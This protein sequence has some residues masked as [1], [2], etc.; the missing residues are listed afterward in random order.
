MKKETIIAII[1]GLIFGFVF[2]SFLITRNR[3]INNKNAGKI[4]P[5]LVLNLNDKKDQENL[6]KK[7]IIN[8]PLEIKEPQNY[9]ITEKNT[10]NISG[11][12]DK[13]SLIVVQSQLKEI[14]YINKDSQDFKISDFPLA[15]GENTIK[16]V[17]YSKNKFADPEEKVLR[18]YYLKR[19]I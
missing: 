1:L 18:V 10:I 16:I 5:T 15:L 2:G 17:E 8:I 6:N 7:N 11:K 9:I 4:N 3:E 19:E 12:A 14:I 13:D